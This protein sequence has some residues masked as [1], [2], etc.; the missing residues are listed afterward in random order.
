MQ[1]VVLSLTLWANIFK[2]VIILESIRLF[3]E[4]IRMLVL[5][6]QS[7]CTLLLPFIDANCS[8]FCHKLSTYFIWV[9]EIAYIIHDTFQFFLESLLIVFGNVFVDLS[10]LRFESL[11][12]SSEWS[13]IAASTD[14]TLWAS[15]QSFGFL[16]LHKLHL[17]LIKVSVRRLGS[18][19][20]VGE[21]FDWLGSWT[22][23]ISEP[24]LPVSQVFP[25]IFG[26]FKHKDMALLLRQ[27][28][29]NV[30]KC[31]IS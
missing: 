1:Q 24:F 31:P 7:S 6:I 17:V 20:Q 3:Y 11:V 23:S 9:I 4:K 27:P 8:H 2:L 25:L 28:L 13:H 10:R 19:R 16:F 29:P 26:V 21:D 18:F 5:I 22:V 30:F 15:L 14:H 12:F